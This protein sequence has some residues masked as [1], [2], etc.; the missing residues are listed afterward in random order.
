MLAAEGNIM[1]SVVAA[2]GGPMYRYRCQCGYTYLVGECGNTVEGGTCP[3]C[4][5]PIG[6]TGGYNQVAAG[7]TRIDLGSPAANL[8]PEPGYLRH[9][10]TDLGR[11]EHTLQRSENAPMSRV[12][13]RVLHLLV[14]L[15]LF[16]STLVYQGADGLRTLMPNEA[17]PV[18]SIWE[19]VVQDLDVLRQ[20]LDAHALDEVVAF[21][22]N[23]IERLPEW[24]QGG[25][26]ALRTAEERNTWEKAFA[27][28]FIEPEMLTLQQTLRR[29]VDE[30]Q[31]AVAD[32]PRLHREIDEDDTLDSAALF[33]PSLFAVTSQPSF[34]VLCATFDSV[35]SHTQ[36]Y[37]FLALF[38]EW[39]PILVHVQQLWPLVRWYRMLREH[40]GNALSRDDAGKTTI[41]E[42][43]EQASAQL[44]A[45][46]VFDE[47][48][49][50]WN[51]IVQGLKDG[52]A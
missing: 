33:Y 26:G 31:R 30:Y 17:S 14:H 10:R 13:F 1:G 24:C 18:A 45:G 5:I 25:S 23:I 41:G 2:L 32:P 37:P 20:L 12:S 16:A 44:G 6:N 50:A 42:L 48:A 28:H 52:G 9:D 4:H 43:L 34:E 21:L 27:E 22:H 11:I 15:S 7:Q 39:Q 40:W 38:L 51:A 47:F 49:E 3:S 19:Q 46:E 35:P 36:V 8:E 29:C